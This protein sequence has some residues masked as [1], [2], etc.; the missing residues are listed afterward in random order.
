MTLSPHD[1]EAAVRTEAFAFL[2]GQQELHGDVLPRGTLAAG[3]LFDGQR[4]PLMG[5]QGIFKPAILAKIPLSITTVPVVEGRERPYEDEIGYD[6]LFYR[7]RGKDPN[8]RD[9]VGLREAMRLQT[10]LI[11]LHGVVP[12]QYLPAWPVYVVDDAPSRLVFTI[13]ADEPLVVDPSAHLSAVGASEDARR[14][15]ATRTVLQRIHQSG[16]RARVLR[17]YVNACAV[18]QLRQ[19]QLLDAAHIVPDSRGGE[20]V[21]PNG[22]ALCKLHHAAFDSHIFGIR[23][24]RQIEVR[25]GVLDEHDGAMLL[26]GLQQ[27]HGE[28]IRIPRNAKLQ[29]RADYLE[30]RYELFRK[31]G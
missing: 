1:L 29:P 12:G 18:C 8:H 14:A 19:S 31:A 7:Y 17:A 15:Y 24:D 30:A 23:P 27:I 26:H 21:V 22:L 16:F 10:P 11:Y 5:P 20:P 6:F 9:N 3:F 25:Q 2:R 4:V 13:R 28:T